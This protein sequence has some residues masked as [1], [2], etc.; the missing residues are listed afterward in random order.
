MF[1]YGKSETQNNYADTSKIAILTFNETNFEFF[2]N[3]VHTNLSDQD[4]KD[5]EYLLQKFINEYN[6]EQAKQYNTYATEQKKVHLLLLLNLKLFKRQYVAVTNNIGDKI[7]WLNC[8]CSPGDKN[9]R[10]E[11]IY[12]KGERMCNFNLTIN[13]TKSKYFDFRLQPI[14]NG[15]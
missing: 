9:W 11:L 7:V 1:W 2:K 14:K 4:I 5:I 15:K 10:K 13:L 3:C 8:F 6:V 12:S